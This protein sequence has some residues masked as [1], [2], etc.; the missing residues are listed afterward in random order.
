VVEEV[1]NDLGR[2]AIA[3]KNGLEDGVDSAASDDILGPFRPRCRRTTHTA[4]T[5]ATASSAAAALANAHRCLRCLVLGRHRKDVL[6]LLAR[7]LP[8]RAALLLLLF[9]GSAA[10]DGRG[11]VAHTVRK[12][13]L[14]HLALENLLFDATCSVFNSKGSVS[15]FKSRLVAPFCLYDCGTKNDKTTH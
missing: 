2:R 9:L 13:A 14:C 12:L 11:A 5:A 1:A 10:A 8:L 3:C 7:E 6:Q 15:G 4:R